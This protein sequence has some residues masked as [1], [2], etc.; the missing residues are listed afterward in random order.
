MS[1]KAK[2]TQQLLA[3]RCYPQDAKA[4]QLGKLSPG[5]QILFAAFAG[6]GDD[7]SP[8]IVAA[9][10]EV[11]RIIKHESVAVVRDCSGA[12]HELETHQM[13]RMPERDIKKP[14]INL[15]KE[16]E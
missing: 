13:R 14:V 8:K 16:K 10:A 12:V 15:Q 5:D 3:E 4:V 9:G 2:T 1:K 6:F 7:G 11:V